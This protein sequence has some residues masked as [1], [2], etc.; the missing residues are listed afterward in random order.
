MISLPSISL[1][2]KEY[3]GQ[4]HLIPVFNLVSQSVAYV[5]IKPGAFFPVPLL[6]A[7]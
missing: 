2:E 5:H 3:N 4:R 1:S 7:L 6:K